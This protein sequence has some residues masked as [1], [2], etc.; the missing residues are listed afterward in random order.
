MTCWLE[1]S[2]QE[3]QDVWSSTEREVYSR[4]YQV[5]SGFMSLYI[6]FSSI[7]YY[8]VLSFGHI[9]IGVLAGCKHVPRWHLC[10]A[11]E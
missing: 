5:K 7:S 4:R 3:L 8:L 9:V 10:L 6:S 11:I 2:Y 1:R